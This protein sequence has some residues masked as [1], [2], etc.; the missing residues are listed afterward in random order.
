MA[1]EPLQSI[2]ELNLQI[3]LT[4][5]YLPKVISAV[6]GLWTKMACWDRVTI[7]LLISLLCCW[8][9]GWVSFAL[10]EAAELDALAS[11]LMSPFQKIL[12]FSLGLAI[13][14]SFA[15]MV[16]QVLNMFVFL[17]LFT[18]IVV[19]ATISDFTIIQGLLTAQE[20]GVTA[21]SPQLLR[22]YQLPHMWLHAVQLLLAVAAFAVYWYS[23][24][25]V[26]RPLKK[27][28]RLRNNR[29]LLRLKAR[30]GRIE[31][32]FDPHRFPRALIAISILI[33][34]SVLWCW[35]YARYS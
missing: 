20:S 16:S 11:T 28:S 6:S 23:R 22:Y 17:T 7:V 34:E 29:S 8:L 14:I 21:M 9:L 13:A 15:I 12:G 5:L 33:N 30:S 19:A 31:R 1:S 3:L 35:R 26:P 2:F 24:K 4:A 25:R 32:T 10:S 27:V 18:L